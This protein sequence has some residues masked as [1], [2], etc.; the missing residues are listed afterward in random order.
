MARVLVAGVAYALAGLVPA[1]LARYGWSTGWRLTSWAISGVI[2]ML[3]LIIAYRYRPRVLNAA[4]EVAI[5]AAVGGVLL[6]AG[7]PVRSHW[8]APDR[9]RV[10]LS[11][12][13]FP[14]IMGVAAFVAALVLGYVLRRSEAREA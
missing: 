7:G 6:A 4:I 10:L 5:G 12:A 13:L 2:I 11:L 14:L 9:S 1:E 3:H 8:D